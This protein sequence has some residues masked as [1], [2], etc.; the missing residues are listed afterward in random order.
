MKENGDAKEMEDLAGNVTV[1]S[2]VTDGS[3]NPSSRCRNP[4]TDPSRLPED[5]TLLL[6]KD[7]NWGDGGLLDCSGRELYTRLHQL[8]RV[9]LRNLYDFIV[10]FA[11][12]SAWKNKARAIIQL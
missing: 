10:C 11:T 4:D 2:D 12:S 1:V 9:A 7:S 8:D 6:L 5:L 3:Q